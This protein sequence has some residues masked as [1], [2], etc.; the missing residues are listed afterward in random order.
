MSRSPDIAIP[1][2]MIAS[3]FDDKLS[4]LFARWDEGM[5]GFGWVGAI[6]QGWFGL[7]EFGLLEFGMFSVRRDHDL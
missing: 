1:V 5:H 3:Q 7:L 6:A 4:G 2:S